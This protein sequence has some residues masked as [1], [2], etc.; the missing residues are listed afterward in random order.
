MFYSLI[1]SNIFETLLWS[2]TILGTWDVAICKTDDVDRGGGDKDND[3]ETISGPFPIS[4]ALP[5]ALSVNLGILK[6]FQW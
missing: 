2:Y 1:H 5:G 3:E 6:A 4:C